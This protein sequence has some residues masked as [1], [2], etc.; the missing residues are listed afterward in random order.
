M[1]NLETHTL[2]EKPKNG[3]QG[4]KHWRHDLMAGLLVSLTSLPFSLGIAIASG[5][6]PIAGLIS[7]I[8][9]G[10]ILPF[11]GGSFVTIS[12]PAAGLAP[13]LLAAM[14]LLG[15]GN[16][17]IGYPRL[18][19]VICMV[20]TIQVVLSRLGAAKLSAAFPAAVVEGMLASIGLMII[21]KELTHFLGHPYHSHEF[22][23]ILRETPAEMG[24]IQPSV[25]A[26]GMICLVLMFVLP[27]LQIRWL[28]SV[29]PPLFVVIVGIALAKLL[30]LG[31]GNLIH[32]P[33]N[34]LQHGIVVP[35]FAGLFADHSLVWIVVTTVLTL[36]M[37]DG[38]ESLATI[39]AVDRIDPF[40]RKSDPDRTLMAMGISNICSSLAGGLT[41][42]PGGVKSKLCVVSGGRTLWANFAN[43]CFLLSY[44]FVLPP[45]INLIPYASLAAILIYTGW[46][47]CEP[48]IWK[49]VAHFGGEQLFLFTATVI[50]TLATDLLWGIAIGMGLK[51][52]LNLALSTRDLRKGLPVTSAGEVVQGSRH[53]IEHL[54]DFFGN[55]VTDRQR[56]GDCYLIRFDRPLVCFNAFHLQREFRQIPT[57]VS[58]IIL[59][60]G[61]R[62]SLID[63]TTCEYLL[64]FVDEHRKSVGWVEMIGIERL[65]PR[66]P[67][68][69]SM[70]LAPARVPAVAV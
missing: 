28:R 65:I 27:K 53:V 48:V 51:L 3:L 24:L 13:A 33:D 47:M 1:L 50:A 18:L 56:I 12:G 39:A 60:F 7:A 6:P 2:V 61:D 15:H 25:L 11:L 62:V 21:A 64:N 49:H 46:R 43:A 67:A 59:H 58:D 45:L 9:A 52:F 16:T 38:V 17:G 70:R 37:I 8:I 36:V 44:L 68:E 55:P 42:I 19:A 4:L 63:H 41:I 54:V 57:G 29:P 30:G 66:S 34:V 14:T 20:G 69:T 5:A 26:V 10:L 35:D 23:G 22:F 32:V 31:G 40:H